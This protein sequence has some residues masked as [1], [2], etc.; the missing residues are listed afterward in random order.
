[1]AKREYREAS[2]ETKTKQSIKKQGINNPNYG[3]Q[4]SEET[5]MKISL[6]QKMA[7]SKIPSKN[8]NEKN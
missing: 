1:M 6:A 7:W 3:K 2:E 5:K 8:D 4:R